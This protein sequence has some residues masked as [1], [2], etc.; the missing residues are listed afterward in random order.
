MIDLKNYLCCDTNKILDAEEI[1]NVTN[2]F[3]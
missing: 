3:V 1:K 2:H